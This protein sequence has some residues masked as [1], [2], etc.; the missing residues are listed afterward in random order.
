MGYAQTTHWGHPYEINAGYGIYTSLDTVGFANVDVGGG[1]FP[2][3]ADLDY[4]EVIGAYCDLCIPSFANTNA[5]PNR[6]LAL[7]GGYPTFQVVPTGHGAIDCIS[8]LTNA[9]Y[10]HSTLTYA[11]GWIYG[12]EN[13][14]SIFASSTSHYY[15]HAVDFYLHNIC[16]AVDDLNI[17]NM[18]FR[19]RF[20][21][22]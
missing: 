10:G 17:N 3:R 15:G 14:A 11:Y 8:T 5:L 9:C 2:T 4:G 22:R 18:I 21:V 6:I 16:S 12:D 13:F 1:M 19:F 20:Y 7:A